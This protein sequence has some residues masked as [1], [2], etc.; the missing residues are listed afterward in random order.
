MTRIFV[1]E[2]LSGQRPST[3]TGA[4]VPDPEL[5]AAGLA[6]R[7]AIVA[8]LLRLDDVEVTCAVR[9]DTDARPGARLATVAARAEESP[10]AF[11]HRLSRSHDLCWIVAP[12]TAGQLKRLHAAVG[13]DRWIGCSADAIRVA[14]SKRAT[15]AALSARGIVTPLAFAHQSS[16]RWLIKPDDGAGT[17]ATR[18]HPD[19]AAALRDLRCRHEA[20]AG[21]TLEPFVDGQALSIAMVVGADL[22]MPIALNRQR[23]AIDRDGVLRDLGVDCAAIDGRLDTRA[24]ALNALAVEVAQ[25]IPGLR[26]FVGID[27]VWNEERGPVV[28]EVNPRVTCAYVGL[29]QKLGR[30]VAAQVLRCHALQETLDGRVS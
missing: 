15:I 3:D 9:D 8:D 1:Y 20:G 4:I 12:E 16:G 13:G 18:V 2:S 6:M 14:S 26:G 28:I 19:R 11:V 5:R 27:L 25:A 10:E 22:A 17:L 7:D 21:A 24:D 29:S 23:I 30:N